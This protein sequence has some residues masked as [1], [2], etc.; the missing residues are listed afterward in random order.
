MPRFSDINSTVHQTILRMR[1]VLSLRDLVTQNS[2]TE[3]PY[4]SIRR[5]CAQP[6]L[7]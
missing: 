6:H 2:V 3:L 1:C 7:Q 4:F 5:Y